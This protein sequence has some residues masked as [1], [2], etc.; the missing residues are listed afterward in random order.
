MVSEGIEEEEEVHVTEVE[1]QVHDLVDQMKDLKKSDDSTIVSKIKPVDYITP[2]RYTEPVAKSPSSNLRINEV[3]EDNTKSNSLTSP[4]KDH[5]NHSHHSDDD[6]DDDLPNNFELENEPTINFI[7]SPNSKPY[8]SINYI[9]QIQEGHDNEIVD[10]EKIINSKNEQILSLSQELQSTNSQFLKFEKEIKDLR[11]IHGKVKAN[12][13]LLTIQLN[14]NNHEIGS[15]NKKIKIKENLV[16]NLEARISKLNH[17]N[18]E[19]TRTYEE[20]SEN[21]NKVNQDVEDQLQKL[22]SLEASYNKK[23]EEI[24]TLTDSNLQFNLKIENLLKEK[25]DNLNEIETLK[26]R[27]SELNE[28]VTSYKTSIEEHETMI[29]EL[30][31]KIGTYDQTCKNYEVELKNFNQ[32]FK[33]LNEI[34]DKNEDEKIQLNNKINELSQLNLN[35]T[36]DEKSL[37]KQI[38][39]LKAENKKLVDSNSEKDDIIKNDGQKIDKLVQ[40]INH[41]EN[42]NSSKQLLNQI[43][44]LKEQIALAQE[45]T[46]ARIHEVAEQ[47]Y[48][49]YSK[50]HE[51]KVNLLKNT[52]R[53][54]IESL[55][56]E[57]KQKSRD[58]ESLE[59]KLKVANNEIGSLLNLFDQQKKKSPN[60]VLASN[61]TNVDKPIHMKKKLS[62]KKTGSIKR[63]NVK[64]HH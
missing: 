38:D 41:L 52:Y 23:A 5:K 7:S 60:K 48:F 37:S 12:E 53:N 32:E 14:Q 4:L 28:S 61:N 58:N 34:L 47:L 1:V 6:D 20:L 16:L 57:L 2:Q 8:F 19:L 64:A 22:T 9:K 56:N 24:S 30:K 29:N 62:P 36:N 39:Q 46:D 51:D 21:Y 45:K 43:A 25:E 27:E 15:L 40:K 44:D 3:I 50:K 11:Q 13:E 49:Q 18:S 35:L 54:Q 59:K 26:L 31:V 55:N 63:S 10:L 42:N 33:N 17:K